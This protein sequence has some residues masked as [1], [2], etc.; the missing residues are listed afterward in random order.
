MNNKFIFCKKK[1][2]LQF[3]KKILGLDDQAVWKYFF[4]I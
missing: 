4:V 3:F 1:I 2:K